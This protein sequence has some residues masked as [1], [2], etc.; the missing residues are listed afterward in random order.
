MPTYTPTAMDVL[1]AMASLDTGGCSSGYAIAGW[2]KKLPEDRENMMLAIAAMC[3]VAR[4]DLCSACSLLRLPDCEECMQI[5][6]E[7]EF[8]EEERFT[9]FCDMVLQTVQYH[10][11]RRALSRKVR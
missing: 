4:V 11:R 10:N 2:L 8:P 6:E 3:R 1:K 5:I 7:T 9:V